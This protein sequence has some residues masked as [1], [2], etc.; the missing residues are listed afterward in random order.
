MTNFEYEGNERTGNGN[1]WNFTCCEFIFGGFKPF[2]TTVYRELGLSRGVSGQFGVA[3]QKQDEIDGRLVVGDLQ[4]K[5][6]Y[7][8]HYCLLSYN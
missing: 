3:K 2:E 8:M 6:V 5:D 4:K 7:L 1:H